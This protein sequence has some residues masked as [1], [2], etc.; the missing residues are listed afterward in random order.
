MKEGEGG[1]KRM[2]EDKR[3]GKGM[4]II[5]IILVFFVISFDDDGDKETNW[6]ALGLSIEHNLYSALPLPKVQRLV[7]LYYV[8]FP[9]THI[10]D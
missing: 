1:L 2:T 3:G 9:E 8:E 4:M 10:N 6:K 5:N 7:A